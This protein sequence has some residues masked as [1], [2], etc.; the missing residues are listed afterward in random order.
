[1]NGLDPNLLRHLDAMRCTRCAGRLEPA[2][3]SLA[4]AAC[5]KSYPILDRIPFLLDAVPNQT[6]GGHAEKLFHFPSFYRLKIKILDVLNPTADVS[7]TDF[8]VQKNVVDVGCGPFTYGYDVTL[9]RSIVG[10]DMSPEFVR[11]MSEQYPENLYFV[12]DAK[13]LPFA[14]QAFDT[15]LLRFV[16]HH[17]PGD[18]AELLREV[19]R[20]TRGHLIIFDHVRSDVPW[21]SAVQ[22]AYWNTFDS[23]HHYYTM[24]EWDALLAPYHVVKFQRTGQMFGNVCQIVLDLTDRTQ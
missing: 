22:S 3:A 18:T 8:L 21:Q 1:M 7:L 12:A 14:D 10:L 23:G 4:C 15:S 16:L 2:Q 5:G 11:A 20:I 9:P 6:S 17:I 24:R 19:T 13:K